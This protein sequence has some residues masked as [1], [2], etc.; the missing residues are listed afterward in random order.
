MKTS[1][2]IR[3]EFQ[4]KTGAPLV[5]AKGKSELNQHEMKTAGYGV[6][7]CAQGEARTTDAVVTSK[8]WAA[9]VVVC[10]MGMDTAIDWNIHKIFKNGDE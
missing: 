5:I 4:I 2:D 6:R 10:K 1:L 7:R 3:H 8:G 9:M